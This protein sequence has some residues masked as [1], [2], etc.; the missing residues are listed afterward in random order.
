MSSRKKL[1]KV[2]NAVK[3]CVIAL[4]LL[5]T[6]GMTLAFA[7]AETGSISGTVTDPSG[8][9][10]SGATVTLKSV[11]TGAERHTVTTD[12]GTYIITNLQPGIYDVKI[13]SQGFAARTQRAQVTVGAK[14]SLD[15]DL[16]A[17][18]SSEEVTVVA[19]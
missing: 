17:Q 5:L 10:V 11:D 8:A 16:S 1:K 19:G 6:Q 12:A 13:E 4:S 14:L 7:Q 15:F 18:A 2:W 3:T 9:V